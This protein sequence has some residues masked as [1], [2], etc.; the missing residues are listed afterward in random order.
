MKNLE[1]LDLWLRAL[2]V[3]VELP[4]CSSV[5]IRDAG[6]KMAVVDTNLFPAG[7]NNL[8]TLS[9]DDAS[10]LMRKAIEQRVDPCQNVLILAEEHTR[11]TWYLEN[12]YSLQKIIEQAGY[13]VKIVAPLDIQPEVF[14]DNI[15]VLELQTAMGHTLKIYPLDPVLKCYE[16]GRQ[17]FDLIIMNNDLM[18]GIPEALKHAHVPIYPSPHA[19]WH[20]R[21]KSDHFQQ[22][23]GLI[24][25][26]ASI[27][28]MDPWLF[29]CLDAVTEDIS[30]QS[31]DDR[32]RLA[33]D[34]E[35]LLDSISDKYRE[36]GI[37]LNPYVYVKADFGTYGMGVQSIESPRD[38]LTLNRKMRNKLS[39]GKSSSDINQFLLQEGVPSIQKVEGQ[40]SEVCVYQIS[41]E[42]AG[43]FFRMHPDKNDRESLNSKGMVFRKI[44]AEKDV[45]NR[46][47][48]QHQCG[49]DYTAPQLELY[50]ILARIAGVAAKSEIELLQEK[51]RL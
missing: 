36:Y 43:A 40:T 15:S 18:N 6:F 19:G 12:V 35:F 49:A 48:C 24:A 28:D 23:K 39:R 33:L 20:A 34:A 41:N 4:L 30:I 44:C 5:D 2:E 25:Q 29:S 7:F 17:Q 16:E 31:E 38:I 46:D 26:M 32:K 27:V 21:R 51:A 1:S 3:G 13:S 11:N 10:V 22:S 9:L 47:L 45:V 8:C 50:K 37:A 14:C 42:F